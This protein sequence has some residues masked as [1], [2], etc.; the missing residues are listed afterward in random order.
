MQVGPLEVLV[1]LV[2]A[3]LIFGPNKLPELARTVGRGMREVRR[4]QRMVQREL[5]DVLAEPSPTRSTTPAGTAPPDAGASTP[6][7]DGASGDGAGQAEG[8]APG[9]VEGPDTGRERT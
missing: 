6:S 4:L 3:L 9:S 2:I 8:K 7:G 1:I 5:D